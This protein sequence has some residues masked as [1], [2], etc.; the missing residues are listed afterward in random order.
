MHERHISWFEVVRM[1]S[2]SLTVVYSSCFLSSSFW[3]EDVKWY[4]CCV[5]I[6]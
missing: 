3:Y 1:V 5:V 2:N 4:K 6:L